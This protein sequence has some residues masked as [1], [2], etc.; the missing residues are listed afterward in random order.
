MSTIKTNAIR[1]DKDELKRF[2]MAARST[3]FEVE[4][5]VKYDAGRYL[6]SI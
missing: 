5:E 3:V 4:V 6:F 1:S 2:S